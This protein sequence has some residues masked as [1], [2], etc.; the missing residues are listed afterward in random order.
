MTRRISV[1]CFY[2]KDERVTRKGK[3]TLTPEGTQATG[4]TVAFK[5]RLR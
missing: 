4:Y 1:W 5:G 2:Y 3:G